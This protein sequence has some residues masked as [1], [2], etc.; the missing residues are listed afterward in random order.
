MLVAALHGCH[1]DG[2][3]TRDIS[4]ETL[5]EQIPSQVVRKLRSDYAAAG[6]VF[7]FNCDDLQ[8]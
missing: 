3:A 6:A 1:I 7:P 5:V 8:Q 2:R 4:R